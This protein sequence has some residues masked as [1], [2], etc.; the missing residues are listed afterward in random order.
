MTRLLRLLGGLVFSVLLTALLAEGVLRV[1]NPLNTSIRGNHINLPTNITW[2]YTG[3][4]NSQ[5]DRKIVHRK[6]N[7][8]FRGRDYESTKGLLRIFTVGGS[9]TENVYLTE[10]KTW[11]DI[12]EHL[13]RPSFPGLW[14]NNAGFVGHSTFAHQ[15]LLEEHIA[16]YAPDVV[17]FL[18]GI[19]D[20]D[21]SDLDGLAL[22]FWQPKFT[23]LANYSELAA[24]ALN[25]YRALQAGERHIT[26]NTEGL[27]EDW[28]VTWAISEAEIEAAIA[29][30]RRLTTAYHERLTRLVETTRDIGAIPVLVTQPV[31]YGDAVDTR[32]GID[33]GKVHVS[34]VDGSTAWKL[35]E[36]YNDISRIV[37]RDLEVKL[38]DL[39]SELP[40]SSYYFYDTLHFTN[41]G[42]ARIGDILYRELRPYLAKHFPDYFLS[43]GSEPWAGRVIPG[44]DLP[45]QT[46]RDRY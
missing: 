20:V 8:G 4:P 17:I 25:I 11:S 9:T 13:L 12:L 7:I 45:R 32:T 26:H 35:L 30:S 10:G 46:A 1:Y 39:A 42:A 15:L 33:L 18:V 19:N 23:E 5:L 21:R 36:L 22:R 41:E 6:N 44:D 3:G 31:L 27:N 34:N 14:M 24:L 29:Y 38:V 2:T 37:A 28:L 16:T 43:E 40:K